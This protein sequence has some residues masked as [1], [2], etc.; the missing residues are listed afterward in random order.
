MGLFGYFIGIMM[1]I[2]AVCSLESFGIPYNSLTVRNFRQIFS[3]TIVRDVWPN[4]KKRPVI[5]AT[6]D[7]HRQGEEDL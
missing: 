3:D 7:I 1:L 6:K 2:F 5:S 4:M